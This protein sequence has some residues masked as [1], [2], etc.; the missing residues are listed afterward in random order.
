MDLTK[1]EEDTILF[2]RSD[3]KNRIEGYL[4]GELKT[5]IDIYKKIYIINGEKIDISNE[6]IVQD[7]SGENYRFLYRYKQRS[8]EK[9]SELIFTVASGI[10][11]SLVS[12][13]ISNI[14]LS[15]IVGWIG[16]SLLPNYYNDITIY[17]NS[18]GTKMKKVI[19]SY[20]DAKYRQYVK[21]S[22]SYITIKK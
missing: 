12:K 5:I 18:R 22:V 20:K 6:E 16:T 2:K 8:R 17:I 1:V 19:K 13:G 7:R 3:D 10:L 21:T 4:N 9:I 15:S 14:A 11:A